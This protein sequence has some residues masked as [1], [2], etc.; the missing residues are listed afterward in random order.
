MERVLLGRLL[1]ILVLG[2]L[3]VDIRHGGISQ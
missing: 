1:C 3:Y 2:L